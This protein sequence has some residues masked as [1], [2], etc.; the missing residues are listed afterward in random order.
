MLIP[1]ELEHLQRHLWRSD[2][3]ICEDSVQL[4]GNSL[5]QVIRQ[6]ALVAAGSAA[7]EGASHLP[8]Q[9]R[10]NVRLQHL[11]DPVLLLAKDVL[12][13]HDRQGGPPW[14]RIWHASCAHAPPARPRNFMLI[15]IDAQLV[16][17]QDLQPRRVLLVR[18]GKRT[19]NGHPADIAFQLARSLLTP[20]H[21]LFGVVRP[22]SG[23]VQ[24]LQGLPQQALVLTVTFA[25][26]IHAVTLQG[27][28]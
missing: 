13:L 10:I 16:S 28:L 7:H 23:Q 9:C 1:M 27:S 12:K 20:P 8:G 4:G 15:H 26:T 6:Q 25:F 19:D 14:L 18:L 21:L 5:C 17:P 2:L 24:L 22:G 3:H 11:K